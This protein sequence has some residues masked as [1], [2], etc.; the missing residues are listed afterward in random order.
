MILEYFHET[1]TAKLPA[2]R[3][4]V[5]DLLEAGRKFLLFAHHQEVLNGLEDSLKK[6]GSV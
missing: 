2:V 3:Q 6:V 5:L 1:A 4:Y